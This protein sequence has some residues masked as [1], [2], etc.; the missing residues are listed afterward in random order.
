MKNIFSKISLKR[1]FSLFTISTTV[2][3]LIVIIFAGKQFFL[4]RHCETL[5]TSSQQLLFQFTGIKEH[6]NETLLN[7][8]KL[9]TSELIKEIQGLDIDLQTLLEDIL[10]PE[11]FKL[12]F[13]TQVD[14]VNITVA[15]RNIQNNNETPTVEAITTLS[16]QLRDIHSKL[17][18]FN[19]L[20]SRYTQKQLLGLHQALVGLL[21]IVIALISI[22]FLVLNKYITSPIIHY[23]RTLFPQES[24]NISLLSLHKTIENLA[25]ATTEKAPEPSEIETGE[26]SRLYRY[27]SIGHLLG[28]LSHELTNLSN[29]AINY[30]QAI[31]DI[32]DDLQLDSDSKELLQKLFT[33]EKKMSHLLSN[34]STFASGS[35]T[36]KA[37]A[38][39][40]DEVFEQV[41]ALVRGTFKNEG[42]DLQ[43]VLNDPA[44]ML[45][46]HVSD[47]QLV[48][49]SALQNCR[50]ALN[51]KFTTGVS[52]QK[53]ITITL[54]DEAL[55]QQNVS[56]IIQDN[57][58]PRGTSQTESNG[59]PKGAWHNMRF[60]MAFLRTFDGSLDV[61]RTDDNTTNSCII[62]LPLKKKQI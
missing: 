3:L 60:C 16:T 22:M 12:S 42:I 13:I 39:S 11:E 56:V 58:A 7:K 25:T 35:V 33:E 8:K 9:N 54:D 43:L 45:N 38:L 23:C 52:G 61:S 14:L 20:I 48:I 47:L 31:L 32:S 30:T 50:T 49:L 51:T 41:R 24:D 5:V 28:G 27:S 1:I 62:T 26:L 15:L 37:K 34:M 21:S 46:N 44:I 4:Y 36:G 18:S 59:K 19:Q 53:K 40:V 10:I 57:G 55:S 6:I 17:N 2:L 29:G